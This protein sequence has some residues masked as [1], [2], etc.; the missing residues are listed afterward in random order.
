[1]RPDI[2]AYE[3]E[4]PPAFA[5]RQGNAFL[6]PGSV[7]GDAALVDPGPDSTE[8]RQRLAEALAAAGLKQTDLRTVVLTGWQPQRAGMVGRL[9]GRGGLTVVARGGA[10]GMARAM[11]EAVQDDQALETA[12]RWGGAPPWAQ[13]RLRALLADRRAMQPVWQPMAGQR[14]LDPNPARDLRL[15]GQAWRARHP[16]GLT[17]ASTLYWHAPSRTLIGGEL[18]DRSAGLRLPLPRPL[19]DWPE[20]LRRIY[21]AW[22]PL[23]RE[24]VDLVL[25]GHGP[26]IR[27]HRVLIARRLARIREQLNGI[28]AATSAESLSPWDLLLRLDPERPDGADLPERLAGL[29]AMVAHLERRGRLRREGPAAA[30][31]FRRATG[32]PPAA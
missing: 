28:L 13:L 26:P 12:A 16:Q 5:D 17:G 8:A 29:L 21:G 4:L 23:G 7:A 20:M 11:A 27:S 30:A 22:R 1:M 15:G 18:L 24:A 32:G 3:I 31:R 25:P 9:S 14:W 2:K 19:Q 6:L 10:N